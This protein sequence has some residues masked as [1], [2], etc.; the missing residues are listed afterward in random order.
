[1]VSSQELCLCCWV[2]LSYA[3]SI[4][5]IMIKV[6]RGMDV[7]LNRVLRSSKLDGLDWG[8][9]Q[10]NDRFNHSWETSC[11]TTRLS[12]SKDLP[13]QKPPDGGYNGSAMKSPL[14]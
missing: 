14:K 5:I 11:K 1:M 3:E 10:T 13:K 4:E 2:A 6:H 8:H 12:R 7:K 9:S